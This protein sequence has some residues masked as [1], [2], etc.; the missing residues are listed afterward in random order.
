MIKISSNSRNKL[1]RNV[2]SKLPT[3]PSSL[4]PTPRKSINMIYRIP[5]LIRHKLHNFLNASKKDDDLYDNDIQYAGRKKTFIQSMTNKCNR[6]F[7][8]NGF[9]LCLAFLFLCVLMFTIYIFYIFSILVFSS[10]STAQPFWE[11]NTRKNRGGSTYQEI[12]SDIDSVVELM[13]QQKPAV[14]T[15]DDTD[16]MLK[17]YH[18]INEKMQNMVEKHCIS[19]LPKDFF[20]FDFDSDSGDFQ[21]HENP[22]MTFHSHIEYFLDTMAIALSSDPE[23]QRNEPLLILRE[24]STVISKYGNIVDLSDIMS[25]NKRIK[26]NVDYAKC[27]LLT[28]LVHK[29]R[30]IQSKLNKVRKQNDQQAKDP[31][32]RASISENDDMHRLSYSDYDIWQKYGQNI[33]STNGEINA[34]RD[35]YELIKFL[36]MHQL[37]I[38]EQLLPNLL[39][40]HCSNVYDF[41]NHNAVELYEKQKKHL[42]FVSGANDILRTI[43]YHKSIE[44]NTGEIPGINVDGILIAYDKFA[45]IDE[46]DE[47]DTKYVLNEDYTT[48]PLLS[49]LV[50]YHNLPIADQVT[51]ALSDIRN[52]NLFGFEA[53]M[54][55][56]L[57]EH[58]SEAIVHL[59]KNEINTNNYHEN[60]YTSVFRGE[61][62]TF[63]IEAAHN[64]YMGNNKYIITDTGAILHLS[65]VQNSKKIHQIYYEC[66]I[67][68]EIAAQS[69]SENTEFAA[70][71]NE[72][73][74]EHRYDIKYQENHGNVQHG[75]KEELY[76]SDLN[77][78]NDAI[79]IVQYALHNDMLSVRR[80]LDTS[81]MRYHV[82]TFGYKLSFTE[83]GSLIEQIEQYLQILIDSQAK[84]WPDSY[85]AFFDDKTLL[86]ESNGKIVDDGDDGSRLKQ[87]TKS[88]FLTKLFKYAYEKSRDMFPFLY[89]K[90]VEKEK[91]S[92]TVN[93]NEKQQQQQQ[94]QMSEEEKANKK[95]SELDA[96]VT[97]LWNDM[98]NSNTENLHELIKKFGDEIENDMNTYCSDLMSMLNMRGKRMLKSRLFSLL[99]EKQK[100]QNVVINDPIISNE[101]EINSMSDLGEKNDRKWVQCSFVTKLLNR[102]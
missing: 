18:T 99:N 38:A 80:M 35:A 78:E 93:E 76:H 23:N 39:R 15:S 13:Q 37:N 60:V 95:E 81:L 17:L 22:R 26:Q 63:A 16:K 36:K 73:E 20:S 102:Q 21:L 32:K 58:C 61:L 14:H 9:M 75:T 47:K 90:E 88:D 94:Q 11:M 51:N 69:A 83:Q 27:S 56:L 54:D 64:I 72:E 100:N 70:E 65:I 25:D 7:V 84:L 68:E 30:E 12:S 77:A 44:V 86:L 87:M 96:Y 10:P 19:E 41:L 42:T 55:V 3:S 43:Y 8:S 89:E 49:K 48:C 40:M 50:F 6:I 59:S 71:V 82:E 62:L 34:D 24:E 97:V 79:T 46:S 66:I 101:G 28:V 1:D 5:A 98:K 92:T 31:P 53:K 91:E 45:M 4:P 85:S 52:N 67:L 33:F 74:W 57:Y 2:F 29:A